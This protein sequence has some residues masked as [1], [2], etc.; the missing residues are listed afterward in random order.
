VFQYP[1]FT[2]RNPFRPL[3]AADESG[4]RY[5][6]LS[7]IGI[8]LSADPS[9]SVAVVSTGG[10]AV[11]EDG[12]VSPIPG[13]AYYLKVGERIGNVVVR[14]IHRDRVEVTVTEFDEQIP[15]TM[16]FASRRPGGTP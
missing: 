14:E 4:P 7:L 1:S 10:V 6:Q 8:M 2:R 3:L 11:A 9:A 16:V 5:E 12:T 13:D 15:R